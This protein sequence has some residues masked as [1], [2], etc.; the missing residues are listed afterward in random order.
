[1]RSLPRVNSFQFPPERSQAQT[2]TETAE[3]APGD[4]V[5]RRGAGRGAAKFAFGKSLCHEREQEFGYNE[6]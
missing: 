5:C 1:M 6:P 3:G 2:Q 4:P